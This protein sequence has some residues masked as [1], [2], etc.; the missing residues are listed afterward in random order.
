[1]KIIHAYIKI[2]SEKRDLFL[3][4]AKTLIQQSKAEPGNISYHLYED[5]LTANSFVMVE[6]WKDQ[7]AIRVHE[8]SAHFQLFVSNAAEFMVAPLEAHVFE[9]AKQQ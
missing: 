9:A 7:E 1:M 4:E 2:S 6:E 8:E 5:P 3:N